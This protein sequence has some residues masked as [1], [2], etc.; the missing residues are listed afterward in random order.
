MDMRKLGSA[1]LET[2]WGAD[3]LIILSQG[4]EQKYAR[5]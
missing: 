1:G 5:G 2:V 3:V 4:P